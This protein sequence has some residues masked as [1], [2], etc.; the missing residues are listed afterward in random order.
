MA[1]SATPPPVNS[2]GFLAW[3]REQF[4]RTQK[5]DEEIEPPAALGAANRI[6]LRDTNGVR[7][8][9]TVSTAGAIVVTAL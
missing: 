7:Y 3:L 4:N 5:I 6:V 8:A 2:P 9:V 1:Q